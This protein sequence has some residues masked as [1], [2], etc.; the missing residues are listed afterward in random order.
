MHARTEAVAR[1][2][3]ASLFTAHSWKGEAQT[4]DNQNK[5]DAKEIFFDDLDLV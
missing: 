3:A 4:A 1:S 2:P 5:D